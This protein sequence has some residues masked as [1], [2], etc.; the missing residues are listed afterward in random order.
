L[1]EFKKFD[2]S[3][4]GTLDID[5]FYPLLKALNPT[6]TYTESVEVFD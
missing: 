1:E 4:D 3:K 5:E 2:L 6:V